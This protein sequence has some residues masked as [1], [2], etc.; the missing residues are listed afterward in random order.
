M[1]IL[2]TSDLHIGRYLNEYSLLDDQIYMLGQI[3]STASENSVDVIVISGDLFDRSVP[4]SQAVAALD[5]FFTEH[6]SS[7][8]R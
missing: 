5:E 3:L 8:S 7:E 1:K 2:H 4:S 6:Y